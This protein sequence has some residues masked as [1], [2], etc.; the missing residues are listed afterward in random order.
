MT[1]YALCTIV[2]ILIFCAAP[3][4][5]GQE[6]LLYA[7]QPVAT[8]N[9]PPSQEGIIVQEIDVKKGDTL[10]KISRKFSGNGMYFPQI[11]LFNSIHNPN[12]I[13]PGNKLKVPI[14]KRSNVALP[15]LP[16]NPEISLTELRAPET[17]KSVI[18]NKTRHKKKPETPT[19]KITARELPAVTTLSA[20]VPASYIRQTPPSRTAGSVSGQ[21]LFEAAVNAYRIDDCRNALELLDRYLAN[22]SD[23]PLAADANLYKAD[24]YLKLSAQ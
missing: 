22:N 11:L 18:K 13:Y 10:Y 3:S 16:H 23:S 20:P 21:K 5:W 8:K 4:S 6:Y 7:P 12:L 14:T 19:G 15:A 1:H 9:M 24:C 17:A 2:T